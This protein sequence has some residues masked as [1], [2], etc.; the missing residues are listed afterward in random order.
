M[1]LLM[2]AVFA[3]AAVPAVATFCAQL[4]PPSARATRSSTSAPM[5]WSAASSRWRSRS[6]TDRHGA[7]RRHDLAR[8]RPRYAG[9]QPGQDR[10]GRR[11]EP[12]GGGGLA[13][14]SARLLQRSAKRCSGMKFRTAPVRAPS[15]DSHRRRRAR[16][17]RPRATRSAAPAAPSARPRRRRCASAREVSGALAQLPDDPQA[18]APAQEVEQRHDR[19]AGARAADGRFFRWQ[20]CF[21]IAALLCVATDIVAYCYDNCSTGDS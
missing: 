3:V 12:D 14:P 2:F 11:R 10:A 19:P 4:E 15:A 16:P 8:R 5:P 6:S 7:D 21:A 18:P 1:Q 17:I 20:A 13:N 9:R